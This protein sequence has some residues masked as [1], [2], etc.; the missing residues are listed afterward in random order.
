M[1]PEFRAL[2]A[3]E[4][5]AIT[6]RAIQFVPIAMEREKV[7]MACSVQVAE[8]QD[9]IRKPNTPPLVAK[10]LN[11]ILIDTPLLCGGEFH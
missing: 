8:E 10:I 1:V 7:A 9:L 2:Y 3:M 4:K 11:N 5:E 6:A